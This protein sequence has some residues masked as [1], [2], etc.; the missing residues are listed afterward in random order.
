[1]EQTHAVNTFNS[2]F[3]ADLLLTTLIFKVY[4]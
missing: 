4:Y 1:M 2:L 3:L